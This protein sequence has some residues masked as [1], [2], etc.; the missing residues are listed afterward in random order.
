MEQETL[1]DQA[2]SS[3][4]KD[5][6]HQTPKPTG[7]VRVPRP[8][9]M[10]S[11]SES[12]PFH[13]FSQWE[14]T[15][16]PET[17][18]QLKAVFR[19]RHQI[20]QKVV[21]MEIV[22]SDRNPK[23]LAQ[24]NV[25]AR[26]LAAAY[27]EFSSFHSQVMALIPDQDVD[28]QEDEYTTFEELY[29]FVSEVVEELILE[30]KDAAVAT[31]TE[32]Q[33]IIQQQPLKAPIPTFDGS[34]AGWPKFK[35]IFNDLMSKSGDSDAFKL[36]HLDKALVG[37]AAGILDARTINEGNYEQAW[38][39]LTDR[40]ENKRVIVESHI[41]GLFSLKRITSESSKDLRALVDE[42]SR[43]VEN[44]RFLKQELLGV[45][46]H[47]VVFLIS[48]ALNKST[49]KAWES[50]LKRGELPKYEPTVKF[51]KNRCQ[52]LENCEA[53]TQ[54]SASQPIKP[55][56]TFA[57]SKP[58]VQKCYASAVNPSKSSVTSTDRCVFCEGQHRNFQCDVLGSLTTAERLEKV[59][60]AGVCFNCLRKGHQSK[61][62]P[63]SN[64]CKKC[65]KHHHTLLHGDKEGSV[66]QDAKSN[67]AIPKP[68]Q[69]PATSAPQPVPEETRT[70]STSCSCN[71]SQPAETVLLLTAV[72]HLADSR[73]QLHPCR[74]LLDSGSQVNF[75][76]EKMANSLGLPKQPAN[77]E[78]TGISAIRTIARERIKVKLHSRDGT[79]TVPTA[80]ID[81]S[82][83]ELPDEI[84]L[85]DAEFHKPSQV[86][87]LIGA[88]HFFDLLKP[89]KTNLRLIYRSFVT[90]ISVGSWLA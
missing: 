34:Y 24:L 66:K 70:V 32:R 50:T 8:L 86:D 83:W 75:I 82:D 60:T 40:Y 90:A 7:S 4:E 54:S 65:Q 12:N 26:N 80:K 6:T 76:S 43:H 33:L 87:M 52:I 44:L 78:I 1:K 81:V 89:G 31:P 10:T 22:I 85:A 62:C 9:I 58:P 41:R 35:A 13:G 39:I 56:P 51:L 47:M 17:A 67:V 18:K 23:S 42:A 49:R 19:Q 25:M 68:A 3:M 30:A 16:D 14:I 57:T 63:S 79:G 2:A 45:S 59:R 46:E 69:E 84:M 64:H 28:K 55:K 61:E 15:S 71:N 29:N 72:V 53:A 20:Y 21:K 37:S 5:A 38:R 88:A 74:V 11:S 36:Y 27:K 77:V 48:N 73:N